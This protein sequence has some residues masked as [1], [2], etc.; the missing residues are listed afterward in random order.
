MKL[1]KNGA[2]GVSYTK[3]SL[4][5]D[6]LR[7]SRRY[8]VISILSALCVTGLDMLSPQLIRTTV[9]CVLGDKELRL[10]G[11]LM[12]RLTRIG[13]IEWLRGHLLLIGSLIVVLALF[14]AVF[15]YLFMLYNAKG[16]ESLVESMRNRLFA[17]IQRLP[18]SWHMRNQ[19]GDIIQ[20]C[21]YDVDTI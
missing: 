11:F 5:L 4:I 6:F 3:A 16:A 19:T 18:F 7:G 13:G 21:T 17:H 2:E 1:P 8:F 9:D 14:S 12:E 20:R 10:P 15:R